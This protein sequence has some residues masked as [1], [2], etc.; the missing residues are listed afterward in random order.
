MIGGEF[1]KGRPTHCR[2]FCMLFSR[3]SSSDV[4]FLLFSPIFD[5]CALRS[6]VATPF[7]E[8]VRLTAM[9][10]CSTLS[11]SFSVALSEAQFTSHRCHNRGATQ[12]LTYAPAFPITARWGPSFEG[13]RFKTCALD[14][15]IERK[16]PGWYRGKRGMT[17]AEGNIFCWE[18][19]L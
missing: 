8:D 2:G 14:P 15:N 12:I 3:P 7:V 6:A 1:P 19:D 10:S 17:P 5:G 13:C 11:C 16:K 4:C 9:D 18:F